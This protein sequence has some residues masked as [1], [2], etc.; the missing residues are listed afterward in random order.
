MP[1]GSRGGRQ[2]QRVAASSPTA[3][4]AAPGST[5]LTTGVGRP[6]RLR[7]RTERRKYQRCE[8]K[9]TRAGRALSSGRSVQM[10]RPERVRAR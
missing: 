1:A 8:G 4:A 5:G 3:A 6:L 7:V 2:C 10:H 9:D